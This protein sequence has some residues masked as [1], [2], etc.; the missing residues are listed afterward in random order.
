MLITIC[1]TEI[2]YLLQKM[3]K[4]FNLEKNQLLE[5]RKES[6]GLITMLIYWKI[7]DNAI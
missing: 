2:I 4:I 5:L 6:I 1:S 3:E 7:K